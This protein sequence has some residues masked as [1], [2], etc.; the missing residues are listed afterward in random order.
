MCPWGPQACL[1]PG[2]FGSDGSLRPGLYFIERG[3]AL[4]IRGLGTL[5]EEGSRWV[6]YRNLWFLTFPRT[7][8]ETHSL[9]RHRK[10][11]NWSYFQYYEA[12]FSMVNLVPEVE[13]DKLAAL[14]TPM[15]AAIGQD[16]ATARILDLATGC[17]YQARSIW[18]HGYKRVYACDVVERRISLAHQF[19]ASTGI[20]F[21]VSDMQ[22]AGFPAAFFDAITISVALHDLPAAGVRDI[23][24][25]CSRMIRPG[26][27]LLILEQRY[28]QDWPPYFRKFYAFVADNLDESLNM[29]AFIDVDLAGVAEGYGFA[30]QSKQIFWLG[31]LCLYVFTQRG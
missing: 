10:Q 27:R 24:R 12:M 30:L 21:L 4:R 23:L 31:G 5:G 8:Y 11:K 9:K 25:E 20:T 19:N 1:N 3:F 13:G 17:G 14:R 15:T 2:Q 16:P 26:G 28:I 6:I 29:R 22:R 18:D 7:W